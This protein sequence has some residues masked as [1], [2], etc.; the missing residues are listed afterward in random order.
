MLPQPALHR[1]TP[2]FRRKL[3][4]TKKC[5]PTRPL[6]HPTFSTGSPKVFH[7]V[8]QEFAWANQTG[9]GDSHAENHRS[10]NGERLSFVKERAWNNDLE[11]QI[12]FYIYSPLI[13]TK[14]RRPPINATAAA[15]DLASCRQ[16]SL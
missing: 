5:V 15:L 2:L 3:L 10:I 11:A 14:T 1:G 13:S 16:S 4:K 7:W 8:T 6:G 9:C 12:I